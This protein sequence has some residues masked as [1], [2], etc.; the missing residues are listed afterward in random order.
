[1]NKFQKRLNANAINFDKIVTDMLAEMQQL[2]NQRKKAKHNLED[3][4]NEVIE[5]IMAYGQ[6]HLTQDQTRE[7]LEKV[8][9]AFQYYH[10]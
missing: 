4:R 8:D 1:M 3:F 7:I 9:T 10:K 6:H 2:R 5:A